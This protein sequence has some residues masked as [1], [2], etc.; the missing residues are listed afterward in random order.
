MHNGDLINIAR[1]VF[2]G[3]EKDRLMVFVTSPAIRKRENMFSQV[4]IPATV[5]ITEVTI[6]SVLLLLCLL[7]LKANIMQLMADKKLRATAVGAAIRR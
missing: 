7:F 6:T 2:C 5:M 3:F 4:S 1:R